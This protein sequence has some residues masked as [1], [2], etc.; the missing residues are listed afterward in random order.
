[1]KRSWLIFVSLLL[2]IVLVACD[3]AGLSI[4]L[5][6]GG[7]GSASPEPQAQQPVQGPVE[8]G[9]D[10]PANGSVL[11]MAPVEIAY[12]ASSADGVATVELAIDGA[13]VSAIESPDASQK[14]VALKYTWNPASAGNHNFS[15]RAKSKTGSWS[16]FSIV[17][18]TVQGS[19][20]QQQ[21]QQQQQA[22][23]ATAT[24]APTNTPEPTPTPKDMTIYDVKASKDLFYYGGGGCNRENTISA[25]ITQPEKAY[26]VVLFIRLVDKEGEG[27]SGWDSGR[28]MSKKGEGEYSVTLFS[29]KIPHW[30]DYDFASMNYQIV[31]QDKA[32][33]RLARSEV[34]KNVSLH[35]CQ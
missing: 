20:A 17:N 3:I 13:V 4:D 6:M 16:N 5:G 30:S 24:T 34:F 25:K 18:V 32:G 7:G 1:M 35:T 10:S 23:Q 27:T 22:P 12:H 11:Q 26:V 28:A 21:Q 19:Q 15:A 9:I 31:V 14:V 8:A 2:A 33:N 29:E